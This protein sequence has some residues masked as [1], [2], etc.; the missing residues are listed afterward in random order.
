MKL[1]KTNRIKK[2]LKKPEKLIFLVWGA[3]T[4]IVHYTGIVKSFSG[5]SGLLLISY[6]ITLTL[7]AA[8][9]LFIALMASLKTAS[10]ITNISSRIL[11]RY[12]YYYEHKN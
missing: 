9:L 12:T 8:W 7:L 10:F 3:A 5:M 4:I 1:L 6:E 11:K 2:D